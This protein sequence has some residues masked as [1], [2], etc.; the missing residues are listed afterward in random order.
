MSTC[1][2][3][4]STINPDAI[5]CAHCGTEQ[6]SADIIQAEIR[7]IAS[8]AAWKDKNRRLSALRAGKPIPDYF[9][10][11][12]HEKHFKSV[13]WGLGIFLQAVLFFLLRF[14]GWA[15]IMM[16]PLIAGFIYL[17][18][19]LYKLYKDEKTEEDQVYNKKLK[20]IEQIFE[21]DID[22]IASQY[23]GVNSLPRVY[24]SYMNS[25][26]NTQGQI[27]ELQRNTYEAT[28]TVK[29]TVG[30]I[31]TTLQDLPKYSFTTIHVLLFAILL[32]LSVPGYEDFIQKYDVTLFDEV[33]KTNFVL[34]EIY[35]LESNSESSEYL[36]IAGNFFKMK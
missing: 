14:S 36:A 15:F 20:E 28:L 35:W 7:K 18:D 34:F 9:P 10:R 21:A 5:V 27:L 6:L 13:Y 19:Y 3:C 11:G 23:S 30:S 4:L 8:N 16:I 25:E 1:Q 12:F 24:R 29:D 31:Q 17:D 2:A 32:A 22:K 26:A 33:R